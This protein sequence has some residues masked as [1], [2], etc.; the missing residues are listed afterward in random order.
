VGEDSALLDRAVGCFIGLAV[1]DAL[2]TT[3]EFTRRD[4]QPPLTDIVGG[5][6][7]RLKP[8]EWTDDTSMAI[9]L[10]E[11]LIAFPELNETDLMERFVRWRDHGEN[12][13]N[14]RFFDIGGATS[15]ALTRFLRDGNPIAGSTDPETAGNGSLMRLAPV[16]LRWIGDPDAAVTAG[17]RQSATTHA[18]PAAVEACAFFAE[19]LV[20]AIRTGNKAA[21]LAERSAAQSD[22]DRVAH[23][24]WDRDRE[25]ICSSGYVIDTLEAAFWAVSRA[26]SFE[27]AVLLAA[28]LGDDADTVAAVTGQLAGAIWGLSGIPNRWL[29]ILAQRD[30]LERLARDLCALPP[31]CRASA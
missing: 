28:N 12:S 17:R 22:V 15:A 25:Q 21:A 31:V 30:R 4:S 16:A 1:G 18:A 20:Q 26:S 23:G 14:G 6:P 5:G 7:F 10:A 3:L 27:E 9:C 19:V 2:G 24:S 8:G 29:E 13:V 11:S